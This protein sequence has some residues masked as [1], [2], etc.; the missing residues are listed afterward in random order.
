M[1]RNNAS[2][3]MIRTDNKKKLFICGGVRFE[4]K[5]NASAEIFDFKGKQWISVQSNCQTV[6]AG[7][8]YNKY[9]Q[10]I[11]VGGG[12]EVCNDGNN[13]K[14]QIYDLMKD[15][16]YNL[17]ETWMRYQYKPIMWNDFNLLFIGS[18]YDDSLEYIDLREQKWKVVRCGKYGKYGKSLLDMFGLKRDIFSSSS[19]PE[20]Y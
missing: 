19:L 10:K 5:Y 16:W 15:K 3:V 20:I 13:R 17:P 9:K 2:C 14:V 18:C 8:C 12:S 4:K 6:D 7:I 11:Y 1:R